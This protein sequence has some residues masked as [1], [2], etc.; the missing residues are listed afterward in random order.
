LETRALVKLRR[1]EFKESLADCDAAHK[2]N[3]E[4]HPNSNWAHYVRG[5]D[6]LKL[7]RTAAGQAEIEAARNL[8]P[9]I[10]QVFAKYGIR[11]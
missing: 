9:D 2:L 7:G 1:G 6:L 4:T 8:T 3:P 10:A 5:L 11:P